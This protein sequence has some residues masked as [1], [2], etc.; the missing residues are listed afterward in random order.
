MNEGP[1]RRTIRNLIEETWMA[2]LWRQHPLAVV[3]WRRN[4]VVSLLILSTGLQIG[5]ASKSTPY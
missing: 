4:A 3:T 2:C 5:A 1:F